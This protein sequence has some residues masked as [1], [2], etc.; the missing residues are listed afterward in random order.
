[1]LSI[2]QERLCDN[3]RKK[4]KTKKYKTLIKRETIK[5]D[6]FIFCHYALF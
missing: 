3:I 1:M 2:K 5:T 4:L 6:L